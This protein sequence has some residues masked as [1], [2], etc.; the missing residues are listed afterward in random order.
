MSQTQ[1]SNQQ[2]PTRIVVYQSICLICFF[3]RPWNKNKTT[4][5]SLKCNATRAGN[6]DTTKK[7]SRLELYI[8]IVSISYVV[9]VCFMQLYNLVSILNAQSWR[10]EI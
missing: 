7:A 9:C 6:A 1:H 2:A 3:D 8:A 10:F 4:K 5:F